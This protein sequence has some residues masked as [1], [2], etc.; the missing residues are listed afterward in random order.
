MPPL[1]SMH[2]RG[3]NSLH[4]T[5]HDLGLYDTLRLVTLLKR[6]NT[7]WARRLAQ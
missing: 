4:Q 6:A 5:R 1:A 2:F 7:R 3:N